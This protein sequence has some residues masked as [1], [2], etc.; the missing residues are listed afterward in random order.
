MPSKPAETET[1]QRAPRLPDKTGK[2]KPINKKE[3]NDTPK[4]VRMWGAQRTQ[5]ETQAKTNRD[6][7]RK[8]S[9]INAATARVL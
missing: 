7:A 8:I 4:K 6:N 1:M 3:K 5:Q 9:I 2:I